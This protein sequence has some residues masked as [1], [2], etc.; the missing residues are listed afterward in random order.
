M[1]PWMPAGRHLLFRPAL[2]SALESNHPDRLRYESAETLEGLF[3]AAF[4]SLRHDMTEAE[5]YRVVAPL[6]ARCH[7]GHTGMRLR[8]ARTTYETAVPDQDVSA[9]FP[10]DFRVVPTIND[11]LS[12]ADPQLAFAV[13]LIEAGN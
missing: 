1:A 10:A 3:D 13:R 8:V 5:F 6:V 11:I 2:R 4:A 12:G 7:C 9:G